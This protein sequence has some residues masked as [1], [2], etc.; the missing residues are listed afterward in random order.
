[1]RRFPRDVAIA[2]KAAAV[3]QFAARSSAAA[4]QGVVNSG[5]VGTLL[6]ALSSCTDNHSRAFNLCWRALSAL[7]AVCADPGTAGV[8]ARMQ[9]TQG[10]QSTA[11][12]LKR[13]ANSHCDDSRAEVLLPAVRYL[14]GLVRA[15]LG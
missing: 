2:W 5:G 11:G 10:G 7:H 8:E 15:S 12:L 14:E 13:V 6:A 4:A 9:L 1:M 3:L